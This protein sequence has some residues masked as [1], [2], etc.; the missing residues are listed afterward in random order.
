M[1]EAIKKISSCSQKMEL[2]HAFTNKAEQNTGKDGL[3]MTM[4]IL[5]NGN[6]SRMENH[7]KKTQSKH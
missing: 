2:L 3:Q 4:E 7:T 1:Y 6:N 5:K